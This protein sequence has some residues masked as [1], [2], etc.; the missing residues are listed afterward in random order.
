M[1]RIFIS[2]KTVNIRRLGT[3]VRTLLWSLKKIASKYL[4]WDFRL[5]CR[6]FSFYISETTSHFR[7]RSLSPFWNPGLRFAHGHRWSWQRVAPKS[8]PCDCSDLDPLIAHPSTLGPTIGPCSSSTGT[9]GTFSLL[10]MCRGLTP[11]RTVHR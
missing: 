11:A 5:F 3:K 1:T 7:E 10:L 6:S 2:E 4:P 9:V 8:L